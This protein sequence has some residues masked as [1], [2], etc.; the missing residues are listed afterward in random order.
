MPQAAQED[1]NRWHDAS[2]AELE[3]AVSRGRRSL[4]PATGVSGCLRLA[5][6]ARAT[7]P[8]R[9]EPRPAPGMGPAQ[10]YGS[11]RRDPR[12][13]ADALLGS[14]MSY[15]PQCAPVPGE[16]TAVEEARGAEDWR[17]WLCRFLRGLSNFVPPLYVGETNS[18]P[19][20][21]RE[22]L[23][24]ESG[25]GAKILDAGVRS[26]LGR[27]AACVLPLGS[28]EQRRWPKRQV[29]EDAVRSTSNRFH[30]S[31]IR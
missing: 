14:G 31:R 13:A 8:H 9:E 15:D 5:P 4:R 25:F 11:D 24:G 17:R 18:L 12:A 29:K 6:S 21:A 30:D 26:G 16:G 2:G 28:C 23:A 27:P 1:L 3:D 20:R 10:P 7:C 19:T 22:H